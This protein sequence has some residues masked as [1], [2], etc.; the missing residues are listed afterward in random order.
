MYTAQAVMF[1]SDIIS[2]QMIKFAKGIN[3]E[4]IIEVRGVVKTP[5]IEGGIKS[6]TQSEIEVD[7]KEIFIVHKSLPR[8]PFNIED[9]SRRVEN[10]EEE[11]KV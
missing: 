5:D 2:P 4:S 11:S 10:Q 1:K 3:K 9:A 8:L 7:I 6:C